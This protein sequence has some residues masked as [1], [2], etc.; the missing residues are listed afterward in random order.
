[1]RSSRGH[2]NRGHWDFRWRS[3]GSHAANC[4]NVPRCHRCTAL[5]FISARY[6]ACTKQKIVWI[7][8]D[9]AGAA[10]AQAFIW[11]LLSRQMTEK[12]VTIPF[13][14]VAIMVETTVACIQI[15]SRLISP[16]SPRRRSFSMICSTCPHNDPFSVLPVS[17]DMSR[18]T[19][20]HK[21]PLLP[22][23]YAIDARGK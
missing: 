2:S 12:T 5:C 19:A 11:Y 10:E 18:L 23:L 1:M 7:S 3:W 13:L 6:R 17:R 15:T 8:T 22:G 14:T 20:P 9:D 16:C 21:A 4:S